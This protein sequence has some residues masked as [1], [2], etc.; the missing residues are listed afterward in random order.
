MSDANIEQLVLFP[1]EPMPGAVEAGELASQQA[2]SVQPIEPE[3]EQSEPKP[4]AR[5]AFGRYVK[6]EMYDVF[7]DYDLSDLTDSE[8][9]WMG[10]KVLGELLFEQ[11]T[12]VP[13]TLRG[14]ALNA[15][16]YGMLARHPQRL[17]ETAEQRS[18]KDKDIDDTVIATGKRA[19]IHALENK[20]EV[21]TAHAAKLAGQREMIKELQREAKKP[22]F[23]HKSPERMK[24]LMSAAW[25]EFTGMLDVVHIQRDWNDDTRKR[26]EAA[27]IHHLT[28]GSQRDR[29][30]HWQSMIHLADGY[31]GARLYLF[32]ARNKETAALLETKN[33]EYT[34]RF[35]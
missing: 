11:P 13:F 32:M 23:A 28:Q 19:E 22:G 3:T 30:A 6:P 25:I 18:L 14:I 33:A 34:Q 4:P 17:A 16:E 10:P 31:L 8:K 15:T 7:G 29:V 12:T 27:L 9:Q 5:V 20:T 21:M 2:V 1:E 35:A 26:A 24:E